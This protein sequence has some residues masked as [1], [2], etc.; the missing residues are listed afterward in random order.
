MGGAVDGG[1]AGEEEGFFDGA[2]RGVRPLRGGEG[3]VLSP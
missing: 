2:G 3:G 1:G